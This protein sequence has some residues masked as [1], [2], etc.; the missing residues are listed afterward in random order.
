MTNEHGK[1]YI[2]SSY[3]WS[4]SAIKPIGFYFASVIIL[5]I[6]SIIAAFVKNL[7][8]MKS[9]IGNTMIR[10][11]NEAKNANNGQ[12]GAQSGDVELEA[13]RTNATEDNTAYPEI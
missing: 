12:S 1:P 6:I 13:D 11:R 3:D 2:Y 8:L 7:I 10:L 4:S 9:D 5:T